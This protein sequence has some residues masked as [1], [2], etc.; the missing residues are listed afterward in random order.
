MCGIWGFITDTPSKE[1]LKLFRRCMILSES[2]GKDATGIAISDG[3]EVTVCKSPI[4][5]TEYIKD[6][7]PKFDDAIS[8]ANLVI[9][10]TRHG[11]IGDAKDN[12]NNHPIISDDWVMIHNGTCSS[13]DKVKDYKYKGQVDSE[14]YLAHIQDKG[15]RDG[16]I[17]IRS[18]SAAVALINRAKPTNLYLFR[19]SQTLYLAYDE[20]TKTI[21]FASTD[22][23]LESAL[24]NKL[25][26]FSS[27]QVKKV[28]EDVLYTLSYA[29]LDLKLS[30]KLEVKKSYPTSY[31][32]S[33]SNYGRY[34]YGWGDYESYGV[35]WDQRTQSF[36]KKEVTSPL[37]NVLIWKETEKWWEK[38]KDKEEEDSAPEV[39]TFG[40]EAEESEEFV[41]IIVYFD[42]ADNIIGYELAD[43]TVQEI[44]EGAN[45]EETDGKT[46]KDAEKKDEGKKDETSNGNE[47]KKT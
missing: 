6:V 28:Y 29:P 25:V 27:F 42:G 32:G 26:I 30:N 18:N 12:N 36:K 43:D 2:R 19:H 34:G 35:A 7:L 47:G 1:N 8:K 41:N 31:V 14:L 5:A 23:I 9:G 39:T 21:F 4:A 46:K 40:S 33:G 24:A 10:H 3:K 20:Q 15:L 17:E 22:D 16:L 11:T 38:A 44:E 37:S 13:L 45:E